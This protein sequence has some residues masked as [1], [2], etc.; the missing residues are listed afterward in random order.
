[1]HRLVVF[2]MAESPGV[3]KGEKAESVKP[4]Q[5]APHYFG[6]SIP[7]QFVVGKEGEFLLRS[8]PPHVFLVEARREVDD[9]FSSSTFQLR[10]ELT[11]KCHQ[12]V[13]KYRGDAVLSEEYAIGII[14]HY[15]GDPEQFL[16]RADA[17]ASFLKSEPL[18]LD[19]KEVS[20]TLESQLKY[21]KDDLVIIDWDG[22]LIFE[23]SGQIEPIVEL[24][25]LANDQLLRYRMLDAELDKRLQ[26]VGRLI[27]VSTPR[28]A[29]S[30]NREVNRAFQEVI[31]HRAQSIAEFDAIDRDIK[32]IG[33]WYYAR[34]YDLAGRKFKFSDWRR[35]IKEKLD[36]LED[37]Y[38]I[39]SENFSV[40]R[41]HYL[42]MIQIVLFFILQ[43]GW[44][45]LIVLELK[46]F[47][48]QV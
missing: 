21:A 31:R 29:L 44:F 9:I 2:V 12:L 34:L 35:T 28:H 30:W 46:I 42:E 27:E 22:A 39:I 13:R 4:L 32:M 14:D 17:M 43:L 7:Q 15:Q 23:P 40:S 25:E 8:Y 6:S 36:S 38:G 11:R 3:K 26:K 5:S 16:E 18:A 47:L 20:Y 33:D 48:R 37:I 19:E 41:L 10:E 24:I 1:M 45:A